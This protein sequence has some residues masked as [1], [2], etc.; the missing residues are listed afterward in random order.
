VHDAGLDSG[1]EGRQDAR[2]PRWAEQ[3]LDA[4]RVAAAGAEPAAVLDR[5]RLVETERLHIRLLL[6]RREAWIVGVLLLRSSWSGQQERIDEDGGAEED[7]EAR[8]DA[9]QCELEHPSSF[10]PAR[11][12]PAES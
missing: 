5:D 3:R 2:E 7:E 10:P 12:V 11:P 6:L 9:A 1:E 4:I 8:A